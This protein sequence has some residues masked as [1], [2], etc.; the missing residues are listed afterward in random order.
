MNLHGSDKPPVCHNALQTSRIREQIQR[1]ISSTI[2]CEILKTAA[3]VQKNNEIS[4]FFQNKTQESELH[5]VRPLPDKW[6]TKA[7]L[8]FHLPNRFA[9]LCHVAARNGKRFVAV[10]DEQLGGTSMRNNLIYLSKVNQEST[11]AADNHRIILQRILH[12]FH[13]GAKHIGTYVLVAQM[14]H[15]HVVAHGLNI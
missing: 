12:L 3:K 11:M 2:N 14:T 8:V 7:N 13:R 15:L 9:N 4:N 5:H 1:R 6:K 10:L